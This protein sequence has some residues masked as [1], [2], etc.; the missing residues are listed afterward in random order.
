MPIVKERVCIYWAL[1][2]HANAVHERRA[3]LG[4]AMPVDTCTLR[5]VKEIVEADSNLVAEANP[6]SW[7]R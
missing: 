2:Y 7:A 5:H 3:A 4:E 6:N 1:R